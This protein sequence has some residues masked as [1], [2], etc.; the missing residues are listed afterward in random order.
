LSNQPQSPYSLRPRETVHNAT[1]LS[2]P[3][4]KRTRE[5]S[6]DNIVEEPDS[7]VQAIDTADPEADRGQG[8]GRGRGKGNRGRG[9]GMKGPDI[10]TSTT[11]N[12]TTTSSSTTPETSAPINDLQ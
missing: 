12:S 4:R 1:P 2:K 10:R 3:L 11:T 9:R 5:E 6:R 7:K 8:S